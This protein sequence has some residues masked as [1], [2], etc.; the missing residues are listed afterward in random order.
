MAADIVDKDTRSRFMSIIKS[1]DTYS[2]LIIKRAVCQ[3]FALSSD[4]KR[5]V[6]QFKIQ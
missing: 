6:S 1:K 3:G 5:T 4:L 2:E